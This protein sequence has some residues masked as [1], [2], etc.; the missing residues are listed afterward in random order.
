MEEDVRGFVTS[1][2]VC[3]QGKSSH[4]PPAGPLRPLPV[5]S[6]PWSHVALDFITGLPPSDGNTITIVTIV[7]RF[8]KAV[9]FVPLAKLPT[10]S[11]T[12]QL[13]VQHVFRLHV[14][15]SNLVSDH[16]P[17]FTSRVWRVFCAALGATVSL[18]SGYHP[19]TNGQTERANQ[20]LESTLRCVV[21]A[22]PSSA[23]GRVCP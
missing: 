16:G 5:L 1:C 17:Q 11:E 8:P 4:R 22:E 23:M 12:A 10:A 14:I 15:P 9:H 7:D 13:L 2:S 6:R 3:A 20:H 21:A 18:S 19:Q